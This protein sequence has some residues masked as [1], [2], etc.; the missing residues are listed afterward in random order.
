M[1]NISIP[2]LI[3]DE[4]KCRKNIR[5]MA[6]KARTSGVS[7][8]PH[9]KTHQ[10][11]TIGRWFREHG[12]KKI[13]V[14]SLQMAEY[15]ADDGWHDIMVAFPLNVR[16]MET[17]N[18]L[19]SRIRLGIIISDKDTLPYLEGHLNNPVDFY[20]KIDVGTHRTGFDPE[21]QD[22]IKET[23]NEAVQNSKLKFKGFVSH[24]GHT[25]KTNSLN[26]VQKIYNHGVDALKNLRDQFLPY[27]PGIIASWG[28]TPS[29]SLVPEFEGIDEIRPG[30][31]IFYDLMQYH[32]G[33]CDWDHIALCVAAPVVARHKERNEIVVYAGAVHLSKDHYQIPN[34][35][36]VFGEVIKF[37]HKGFERF[38]KPVYV[39]RLSQ[40][41]GVIDCPD[42]YWDDFK[43]GGLMGV[44]PVHSCLAADLLRDFHSTSGIFLV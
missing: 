1:E 36:L 29:C 16:E 20:L 4:E 41:H 31:F 27:H 8:R 2:T 37:T 21:N 22:L 14:S 42:E 12:V 35:G 17:V 30:N 33:S 25:Y 28:D 40:E 39:T 3:V 5:I 34:Y 18:Q 6:E 19:A 23:I 43:V 24:A 38:P 26:E 9:F 7:F 13:T 32:L 10:S 15:F 11:H 44:V